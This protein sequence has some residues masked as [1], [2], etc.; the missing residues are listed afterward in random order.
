MDEVY[1]K[2]PRDILYS[3]TVSPSA[4]TTIPRILISINV[5]ISVMH[6][7]DTNEGASKVYTLLPVKTAIYCII[8]IIIIIKI[9]IFPRPVSIQT[10]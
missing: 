4:C 5:N 6:L 2:F 8:I 3:I 10:I 1:V 9:F 7:W